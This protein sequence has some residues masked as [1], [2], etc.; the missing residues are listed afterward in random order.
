VT[1]SNTFCITSCISFAPSLYV[2][3]RVPTYVHVMYGD[4]ARNVPNHAQSSFYTF[5][6]YLFPL[7]ILRTVYHRGFIFDI[8]I[9]LGE[10]LTLTCVFCVFSWQAEEGRCPE[11]SLSDAGARLYNRYC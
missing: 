6:K 5:V 4:L 10:G 8:I 2:S 11:I 9:G 3:Y 1:N 7:I